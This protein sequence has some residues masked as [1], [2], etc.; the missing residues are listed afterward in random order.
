MDVRDIDYLIG[1][2]GGN[3]TLYDTRRKIKE[4]TEIIC[5]N[6]CGRGYIE[7]VLPNFRFPHYPD[8]HGN[9]NYIKCTCHICGGTGR[10][11]K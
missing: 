1:K 4:E 7:K 3:T 6:C 5:Q 9:D 8:G 11:K 2:Y 10:V